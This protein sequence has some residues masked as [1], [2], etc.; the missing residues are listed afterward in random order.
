MTLDLHNF[1]QFLYIVCVYVCS[2][3]M[4]V[5]KLVSILGEDWPGFNSPLIRNDSLW[6]NDY[7]PLEHTTWST[8]TDSTPTGSVS[9]FGVRVGVLL[10]NN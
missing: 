2:L 4:N 8:N 5:K 7:N 6:D 9:S 1:L 10:S 3:I